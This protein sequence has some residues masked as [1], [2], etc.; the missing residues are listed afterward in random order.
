MPFGGFPDGKTHLTRIPAAFFGELLPQIDHLG[1]LKLTLYIFW[2]LERQEG[3]PRYASLAEIASDER[4]TASLGASPA[5]A[6][7][8]LKDALERAVLRGTLLRAELQPGSPEGALIFLNSPRG[9]AAV[10]ALQAGDWS[11][12][13]G[14]RALPGL[15]D[16]RPNIFRLYEENIGPLTALIA[17]ELR[18]AEQDFPITWI[19]DAI[20]I[21]VKRNARN[22][23]YVEAILRSWQEKGRDEEDRRKSEKDSRR[24]IEGEFG[25]FIKH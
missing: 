12:P 17:E 22:W 1:E 8:A 4:F 7:A 19:E 10:R 3:S 18:A 25:D 21:A 24:Y 11:P 14:A 5:E 23:R 2:L 13:S 16:E 6:Q 20:R 9:R 15:A